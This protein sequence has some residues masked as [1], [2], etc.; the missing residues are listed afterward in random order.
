MKINKIIKEIIKE[1]LN[2]N[3]YKKT[4]NHEIDYLLK[5]ITKNIDNKYL[6]NEIEKLAISFEKEVEFFLNNVEKLI[7]MEKN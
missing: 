7:D 5:D 6:E 4:F 3:S 2:I 1:E